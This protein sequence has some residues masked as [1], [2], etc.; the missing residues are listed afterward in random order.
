MSVRQIRKRIFKICR[1]IIWQG[2][3]IPNLAN[4][5]SPNYNEDSIIEAEYK[6]FFENQRFQNGDGFD[7]P[8][9]KI[10]IY[11]NAPVN[12]GMFYSSMKEPC[13]FCHKDHKDNCDLDNIDNKVRLKDIINKL[14][15]RDLY[16]VV[17]WKDKPQANIKAIENPEIVNID[18]SGMNF[19]TKSSTINLYDCLN[20][21]STEEILSGNDKWYCSKCKEHVNAS[22]KME[23]YKAPEYLIIH[24]KRFSHTRNSM[25]GSRKL[26]D[27]IDFPVDGLDMTQ[28][29][30]QNL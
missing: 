11:N 21:F 10:Q 30:I 28:Y 16:L 12:T 5:D 3:N 9:Y 2:Q 8:L 24:L 23:I 14:R 6:Y 17:N 22:K 4:K 26:N 29:I 27:F 13:E 25:F 7:N 20:Y 1:P 15:E 19:T 18:V